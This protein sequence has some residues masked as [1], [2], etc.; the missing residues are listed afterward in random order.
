MNTKTIGDKT[1]G[2]CLAKLLNLDYKVLIPFGENQRYDLVIDDNGK[3]I[4]IQCKTG[5]MKNGCVQFATCSIYKIK[6]RL[7]K[8]SYTQN[9]IDCIMIYC[10]KNEKFYFI[11][12][13]EIPKF[14]MNLRLDEP[15]RKSPNI[16]WAINYEKP[17]W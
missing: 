1:E 5:R 9:E 11:D 4:R 10:P 16:S 17:C 14:E 15:K 2:R 6:G 7:F 12:V 13:K 8:N 3:F